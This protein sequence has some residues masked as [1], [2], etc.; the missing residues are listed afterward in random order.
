MEAAASAVNLLNCIKRNGT[1]I[2]DRLHPVAFS[3][4]RDYTMA[5]SFMNVTHEGTFIT[6][7]S[8]DAR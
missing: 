1:S 7:V 4:I 5:L 2:H 3:F 6:S 8:N